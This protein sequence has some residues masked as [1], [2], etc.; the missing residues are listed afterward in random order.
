MV[1]YT[2]NINIGGNSMKVISLVN[3]KGG[4]SKTVLVQK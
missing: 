3:Q 1:K 4:V 2:E